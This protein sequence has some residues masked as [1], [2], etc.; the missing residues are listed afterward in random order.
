M[1]I[2]G[3]PSLAVPSRPIESSERTAAYSVVF[4]SYV[5]Y[6][7]LNESYATADSTEVG[8]GG[9]VRVYS[10]SRFRDFVA[11]NTY[12]DDTHPQPGPL[13]HYG[14]ACLNHIV[15]VI[16]PSEPVIDLVRTGDA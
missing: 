12:A 14:F 1:A 15:H 13:R 6:C 5:A 11:N 16:T 7:V 3:V 10:K 9:L 4:K 8:T 2:V